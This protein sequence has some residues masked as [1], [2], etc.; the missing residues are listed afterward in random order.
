ME[1]RAFE[2]KFKAPACLRGLTLTIVIVLALLSGSALAVDI[3]R[4]G[5]T[6]SWYDPAAGGQGIEIEVYQDAMAPGVGYLQG[7]WA[8]FAVGWEIG[9]RWYTFGGAVR[10]GQSSATFTLFENIGGK[11]NAPTATQSVP[12]GSVVLTFL[13]CSTASMTYQDVRWDRYWGPFSQTIPL[14][15]LTP[16]VT[17]S[18]AGASRPD[19]DFSYSGHWFDPANPGQG[20]FVDLNPI[21]E[22]SFVVWYTYSRDGAWTDAEEEVQR[23]YTGLGKFVPGMSAVRMTLYETTGGVIGGSSDPAFA[24]RT[25]MVGTAT[26]TFAG[27][28]SAQLTFNFTAGSNAGASG[29][30]NLSRVGPAPPGCGS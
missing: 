12:I 23:W 6:G 30:V 3:N 24:I 20:L 5:L 18:D 2:T 13:D 26:A 21:A 10:T 1:I 11:F 19:I 14:V 9:Q 22:V 8:T 25:H 29:T 17:C 27:C 16:N 28:E 15:R 4:H 7:S